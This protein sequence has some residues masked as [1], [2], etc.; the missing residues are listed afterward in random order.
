MQD[1]ILELKHKIIEVL[2]L[3]DISVDEIDENEALFG[4]GL[5]LDL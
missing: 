1:L 2:N 4:D 5:G 3:E